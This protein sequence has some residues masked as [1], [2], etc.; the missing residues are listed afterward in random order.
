[1]AKYPGSKFDSSRPDSS[2][3]L[4]VTHKRTQRID[5]KSSFCTHYEVKNSYMETMSAH[6]SVCDMASA[7]KLF[8]I[9]MKLGTEVLYEELLNKHELR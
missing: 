7:T 2:L 9:Y 5:N 3:S 4:S 8:F 1:M 6:P